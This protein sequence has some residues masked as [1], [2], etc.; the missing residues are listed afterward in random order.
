MLQQQFTIQNPTGIHARPAGAILKKASIYACKVELEK[1]DGT[2][3]SAKSMVG[4]LKLGLKQGEQVTIITDGDGEAE[5]L[6]AVGEVVEHVF[7]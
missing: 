3:V 4:L 1:A 7:E 2:R 6:Q 5:A